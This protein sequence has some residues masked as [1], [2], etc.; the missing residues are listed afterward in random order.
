ME[1]N[2]F[3]ME[4]SDIKAQLSITTVLAHYGITAIKNNQIHCPFHEDKSP[5]M[6]VY[7]D[8]GLVYCHSSNC[9]NGGKH[10]DQIEIIQQKEGCTKHEAIK[11]A[12]SLITNKTTA[13]PI[14]SILMEEV[15]YQEIFA[16]S[17]QCYIRNDK[18]QAYA[19]ER[20]INNAKLEIGFNTPTGTV[21]KSLKNCI[22]FP[23]KN[24]QNEIVSLYGRSIDNNDKA[25]H[26]YSANRKG[27]YHNTN[28]ETTTLI[29]TES[30]IDSATI[31]VHTNFET[32]AL[33]GTNGYNQEHEE[34][35][36][37]IPN[38]Q[39]IIFFLDG[40]EAGKQAVSKHSETIK[41][42]LPTVTLSVVEVPDD[43]DINSLTISHEAEILNHLIKERVNLF[44]SPE[45]EKPIQQTIETLTNTA[46]KLD[47]KNEDY[48]AFEYENLLMSII[49]GVS[50]FPLD[51]LKITL[52]ITRTDSKN[53]LHRLRQSNLDLYSEE[54]LQRFIRTASEKLEIGT[55]QLNL[56]IAELTEELEEHR[57]QKIERQ[58]PKTEPKKVLS[59]FRKEEL[60]KILKRQDL[61]Q[62]INQL[63]GNTGIIGEEKNR[64]VMWTVFTSRLMENPLHIICLGAS[65]TGKTYLQE[66]V[67][68]LFPK[69]T[70]ISFT[71]STE[72]AFYYV[73]RTELKHKIVLVEDMDGASSVLYVLRELQSKS[74]VSKLVPIKDSKGNMQTKMLEVEGPIVL[75]GTTTKE[76]LYEDN[77][78][79]CLLI[80]LDN[81]TEQQAGIMERQRN[82]SAG[83][84]NR[85]SEQSTIELLQDLQMMFRKINVVNPFATKLHIPET[86]FKPLRTNAHYL[87]FIEAITFVHQFQRV[88]KKD[89]Q[90]NEFIETTLEDIELA[91]ELLK[92]ILLA[93]SD[94]LTKACRDFLEV[95][96][97]HLNNHK[98][99]SFFRS[100]VREWTRINPHN[101]NHYLK[102]L[103]FYGYIR[104]IGGNK[105][106]GGYEY[107]VANKDE[108]NNL[109]N[110][111]IT[112][113]DKALENIRKPNE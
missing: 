77:A 25:K 60:L 33:F 30:I 61:M 43:E 42:L 91:N 7:E 19:K 67:A 93:K 84:I 22:I 87:Q 101:I 95:L 44:S 32:L 34:L 104:S 100:D 71:A 29:I 12:E 51:K 1:K 20:N 21:F 74:Y 89:N 62:Y 105:F 16:K 72:Q 40:D 69:D 108:Y 28:Q 14:K 92:E 8:K 88:I 55:K 35:L 58:K 110:S 65:G 48:L 11:K 80:Y 49:G 56:A 39:E 9:K 52:G 111:V 45:E 106:K 57:N 59:Q 86:V 27:L 79:R 113:L 5:S 66:R 38:L 46:S 109:Q 24:N 94:E 97:A 82:V 37:S 10:L 64:L 23:L 70:K 47:T 78:N 50:L 53:K 2:N 99:A 90:G 4:I 107:E 13:T 83:L 26:Y 76:K 6:Q 102:T 18:A 112:A 103:N 81:S 85:A 15:N 96:K 63:I 73:G 3:I 31:Q 36:K 41:E 54:Q 75:S 68:E 17:Q 98:R